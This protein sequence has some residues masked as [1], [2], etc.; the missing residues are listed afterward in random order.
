MTSWF[1]KKYESLLRKQVRSEAR[2]NKRETGR[3]CY[4]FSHWSR[5]HLVVPFAPTRSQAVLMRDVCCKKQ[6][7]GLWCCFTPRILRLLLLV[8]H[9]GKYI[10]TF[11][12]GC[13]IRMY[14][15]VYG[16]TLHQHYGIDDSMEMNFKVNVAKENIGNSAVNVKFV[17]HTT[18]FNE[19]M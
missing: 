18:V 9:R 13:F 16:L 11:S 8:W 2:S 1:R 12:V 6:Q 19:L 7:S 10:D 17:V 3:S 5:E 14:K 15:F 4:F